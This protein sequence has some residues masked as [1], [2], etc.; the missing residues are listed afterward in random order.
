MAREARPQ[1]VVR[2][3]A[4]S[5]GR[6]ADGEF[7]RAVMLPD[8]PELLTR[9]EVLSC[10]ARRPDHQLLDVG[11]HADA[12]AGAAHLRR[13][14]EQWL[15]DNPDEKFLL[16]VDEAHL[17]RGA[18]GA[19]V[20]LLLRRLR[21]RLGI[22]PDRLQVI[23]TSASFSDAGVRP[24]LRR[25]ADRQGRRRLPTPSPGSWTLRSRSADGISS[26]RRRRWPPC[27]WRRSTTARRRRARSR[28]SPTFLDHRGVDAIGTHVGAVLLRGAR[29]FPPMSLL[30]NETMQKA[31]PVSE[32]GA[33]RL[34]G[35]RD[36]DSPTGR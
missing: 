24:R 16:V 15:Q 7:V 11:V 30:V 5:A 25:P 6:T 31:Q 23:A 19:E 29:D 28:P 21:A 36:R 20:A 35:R 9:H 14:P 26:R 17:Y 10:A 4:V 27:R 33:R 3:Q 18:A 8:D 1:G 32:L 34:S 2:R 22:P 12:A 13:T